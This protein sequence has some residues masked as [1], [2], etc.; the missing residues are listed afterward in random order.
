M[1]ILHVFYFAE[2]ATLTENIKYSFQLS[3]L[4]LVNF[5]FSKHSHHVLLGDGFNLDLDKIR[6]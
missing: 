2:R 1:S 6:C 4:C 5:K 3:C